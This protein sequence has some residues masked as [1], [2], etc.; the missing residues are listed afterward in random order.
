LGVDFNQAYAGVGS[1]K[2]FGSFKV[3]AGLSLIDL[4]NR[5]G[6]SAKKREGCC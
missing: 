3:M 2:L 4:T 6:I 5:S 1:A